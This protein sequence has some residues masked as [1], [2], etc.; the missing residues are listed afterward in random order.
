LWRGRN[1]IQLLQAHVGAVSALQYSERAGTLV[2]GGKDGKINLYQLATT[3]TADV[4]SGNGERLVQTRQLEICAMIDLMCQ[5]G[6][7]SSYV[8]SVFLSGDRAKV[9]VTTFGGEIKELSCLAVDPNAEGEE[10]GAEPPPATE[11]GE[12]SSTPSGPSSN[13]GRDINGG[14]LVRAHYMKDFEPLSK[15]LE[16]STLYQQYIPK[17]S[18]VSCLCKVAGGFLSAGGDGTIRQWAAAEGEAHRCTKITPMD[19]GIALLAASAT[20]V[21]CAYD[22]NINLSKRGTVQIL[23]FPDMNFVTEIKPCTGDKVGS[24]LLTSLITFS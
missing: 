13:L 22:G 19:S 9:L 14:S 15:D 20:L 21:A 18:I 5:P 12:G 7:I 2:S 4:S 23:T 10:G 3:G 17:S 8:R 16:V 11:E 1:C 24:F 6:I